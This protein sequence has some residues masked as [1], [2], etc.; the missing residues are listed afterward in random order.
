MKLN[1]VYRACMR[2]AM[3]MGVP[4]IPFM[5]SFAI[6]VIPAASYSFWFILGLPVAIFIMQQMVKY[7]EHIFDV[8][9]LKMLTSINSSSSIKIEKS[10]K[11]I[12]PA[13]SKQIL[14]SN[15]LTSNKRTSP[16]SPKG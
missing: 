12:S 11:L 4:M 5:L 8:I 3:F 7:D 13:Q 14:A 10:T 15:M 16:T 2:P 9:Y 1:T 6:F